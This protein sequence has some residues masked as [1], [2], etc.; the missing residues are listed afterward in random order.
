MPVDPDRSN[1]RRPRLVVIAK[2]CQASNDWYYYEP[3]ENVQAME[4]GKRKKTRA[5]YAAADSN[6]VIEQA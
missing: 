3:G 4:T 6:M 2:K 1:N 5:K